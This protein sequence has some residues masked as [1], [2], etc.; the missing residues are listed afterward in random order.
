MFQNDVIGVYPKAPSSWTFKIDTDKDE[1]T[2]EW[3]T[4]YIRPKDG[5][6]YDIKEHV[7]K[8]FTI[9]DLKNFTFPDPQDKGRVKGLREEV[10]DLH[11]NT[12]KA[13][14]MYSALWGLW[15]SLWLFRGFEQSY[16]DIAGNIKFVELFFDKILWWTKSYWENVLSEVGDLVDVVQSVLNGF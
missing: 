12:D 9:D 5:Y 4:R 14:I 16:V 15:E 11:E 7:M 1:F 13:L 10:L 6:F 2:D 8:D 3:G